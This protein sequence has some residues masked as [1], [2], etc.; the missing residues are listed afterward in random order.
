MTS[1]MCNALYI[2][3]CECDLLYGNDLKHVHHCFFVLKLMK[4]FLVKII[5]VYDVLLKQKLQKSCNPLQCLY[6][7]REHWVLSSNFVTRNNGFKGPSI[8]VFCGP[9]CVHRLPDTGRS[10]NGHNND[11]IMSA[12]ASRITSLT[13]VYSSV[14]SGADQRKCQSSASLAFVR[15]IY[16]WQVNSTHKGPVT[17][18]RFHLMTSS[19]NQ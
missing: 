15:G 2:D 8:T 3:A 7:L 9:W 11:V 19:C 10:H 6:V 17:R 16:R 12:M 1:D 5:H 4:Y 18:K 13:T 14:Y